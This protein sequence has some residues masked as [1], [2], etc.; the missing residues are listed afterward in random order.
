[1]GHEEAK[2]ILEL[3]TNGINPDTGSP[4]PKKSP[5]NSPRVMRALFLA[6]EHIKVQ[7]QSPSNTLTA[8]APKSPETPP[9]LMTDK[10]AEKAPDPRYPNQGQSWTTAEDDQLREEYASQKLSVGQI[11]AIHQRSWSGIAFRLVS[12]KLAVSVDDLK[13]TPIVTDEH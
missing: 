9:E 7:P 8:D 10:P 6:L 2:R 4:L 1:M 13:N 3:L 12:L 5:Y 11:A